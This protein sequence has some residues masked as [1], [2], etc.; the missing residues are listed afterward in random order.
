MK[1]PGGWL[2]RSY[3]KVL[4][5]NKDFVCSE[6]LVFVPDENMEWVFNDKS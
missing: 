3:T 1:V 5:F 4:E 2:V 6:A